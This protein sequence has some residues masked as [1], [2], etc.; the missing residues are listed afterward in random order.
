MLTI[1]L[2]ESELEKIPN[3]I[4]SHPSVTSH[5][6]QFNK[7]PAN[8]ILDASF[9]HSA[10]KN[11]PEGE[12]R[13]RPDITHIFLLTALESILNKKGELKVVVHT[14]NNEAI[15]FNPETR[16]MKSYIRFIGLIEQLFEKKIIATE[17]KTL[18]E[19]REN[20]TLENLIDEEKH[21]FVVSF[22]PDGKK[23]KLSNYFKELKEKKHKNI[24]CIVGGFPHGDFHNDVSKYSDDVISIY[25]ETLT[26][27][28]VAGELLIN[29]E[30]TF[31]K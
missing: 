23:V 3:Q 10:M 30:N 18:L 16:L 1:I 22:S 26:A 17:E 19:L 4:L 9:H 14:R 29:Y 20:K 25:D 6:R 24:L 21:D 2:A 5:S 7:R 27:W 8:M 11:I 31:C 12:R 15:Y 28:T 13:G